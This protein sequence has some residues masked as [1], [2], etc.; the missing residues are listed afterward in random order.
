MSDQNQF[1]EYGTRAK[2]R[3]SEL[4]NK[5]AN[6][7]Y[8]INT[9]KKR[10]KII[11]ETYCKIWTRVW[12]TKYK[13]TAATFCGWLH[14]YGALVYVLPEVL[15]YDQLYCHCSTAYFISGDKT[16]TFFF[17]FCY[18]SIYGTIFSIESQPIILW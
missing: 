6:R 8:K 12:S 13:R 2:K 16:C 4:N 11:Y 18:H 3:D 14:G 1:M 17:M 5:Q 15:L 10:K 7:V 9:Q